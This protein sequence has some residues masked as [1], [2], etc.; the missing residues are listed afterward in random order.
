[1]LQTRFFANTT[2][3][4]KLEIT[5]NQLISN[6]QIL[7]NKSTAEQQTWCNLSANTNTMVYTFNHRTHSKAVAREYRHYDTAAEK[8]NQKKIIKWV[9]SYIIFNLWSLGI[10]WDRLA[11]TSIKG[12]NRPDMHAQSMTVYAITWMVKIN[13]RWSIRNNQVQGCKTFMIG[14]SK[15]RALLQ[16]TAMKSYIVYMKAVVSWQGDKGGAMG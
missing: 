3:R 4:F 1:M 5:R 7:V 10:P 6:N 15:L 2:C 9:I 14:N 12:I 11:N 16:Q 13:M 8:R